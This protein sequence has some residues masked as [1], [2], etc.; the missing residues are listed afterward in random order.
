MHDYFLSYRSANREAAFAA[1]DRLIAAGQTVWVD[2]VRDDAVVGIPAGQPHEDTIRTAIDEAGALVVFD[3]PEWHESSYCME[4]YRHAVDNGKRVAVITADPDTR[5]PTLKDLPTVPADAPEQLIE[6]L[7]PGDHLATVHARLLSEMRRSRGTPPPWWSISGHRE[8]ARDAVTLT[9]TP[10]QT[11]GLSVTQ[12]LS[13]YCGRIAVGAGRRRRSLA[14]V[15]AAGLALLTVLAV[16]AGAAYVTART[17]SQEARRSA[18]HAQSLGV[19]RQAADSGNTAEALTLAERSYEL[20]A[21][22]ATRSMLATIRNGLVYRATLTVSTVPAFGWAVNDAGTVV[23]GSRQHSVLV[24]Y[25]GTGQTV[26]IASQEG[27][28]RRVA[29]APD[30]RAGFVVAVSGTLWCVDIPA[31]RMTRSGLTGVVDLHV[32]PDGSLWWMTSGGLLGHAA[33]CPDTSSE[34]T[35]T[36]LTDVTA[37][38]VSPGSGRAYVLTKSG[39]FSTVDLRGRTMRGVDLL[40]IPPAKDPDRSKALSAAETPYVIR[41]GERIHVLTGVEGPLSL[42]TWAGFDLDGAPAGNRVTNVQMNGVGCAPGGG[43]WAVPMLTPAP[44]ALPETAR[45]P[46]GEIDDRDRSTMTFVANSADR[47]RTVVAHK[48]GRVNVLTTAKV[49]WSEPAGNA[50]VAVP[51]DGGGTITVDTDGTARFRDGT[52]NVTIGNVNGAPG[53]LS[54]T[55]GPTA[56]IATA[57][58]IVMLDARQVVRTVPTPGPVT[59]LTLSRGADEVVAGGR[60]WWLGVPLDAAK[61]TRTLRV[62]MLGPG[63]TVSSVQSDG[64]RLLETTSLGRVMIASPAGEVLHTVQLDAAGPTTAVFRADHGIIATGASGV[65]TSYTPDLRPTGSLLLGV[66][67]ILIRPAVRGSTL[68]VA[69]N[70]YSVWTVDVGTLQPQALISIRSPDV[71]LNVPAPDGSRVT[72]LL[73][74]TGGRQARLETIPLAR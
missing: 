53:P 18:D 50:A 54:L 64:D 2:E 35:P 42:S 69:L 59:S 47:S 6:L 26:A 17:Q 65:L 5:H 13:D 12:E 62:P 23:L 41:C 48:D 15:G 46:I 39:R 70:D 11:H 51:I 9:L 57:K 24:G 66:N 58:G 44:L 25:P 4:E 55:A 27:L 14:T 36:D 34:T 45:F 32:Q 43:S 49:S 28:G 7:V 20:E 40:T 1:R 72:V 60:G 52:G 74:A 71:R 67:A 31:R 73:P 37:F 8:Q 56:V 29:V 68:V 30:G 63:E 38:D 21:N 61:P 16:L 33:S 22:D 10:V 3:T 19:A